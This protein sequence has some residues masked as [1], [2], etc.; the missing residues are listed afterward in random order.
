MAVFENLPDAACVAY[1]GEWVG[2]EQYKV[3]PFADLN[4]SEV[5]LC[6]DDTSRS[7]RPDMDGLEGRDA[8]VYQLLEFPV[9]TD[10]HLPDIRTSA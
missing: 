10:G 7:A 6:A 3:G 4:G 2:I 9:H 5:L 8:G 1:I